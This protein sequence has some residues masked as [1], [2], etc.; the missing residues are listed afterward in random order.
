MATGKFPFTMLVVCGEMDCDRWLPVNVDVDPDGNAVVT[1][2]DDEDGWTLDVGCGD[3][4]LVRCPDHAR[5][6]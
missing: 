2:N 3:A 4:L 6:R 1:Q 5:G